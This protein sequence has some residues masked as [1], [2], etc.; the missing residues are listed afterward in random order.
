MRN[1][2][3]TLFILVSSCNPPPDEP[4]PPVCGNG[5]TEIG[6]ECDGTVPAVQTCRLH[7]FSGGTVT[8]CDYQC[9]IVTTGCNNGIDDTCFNGRIDTDEECDF[10]TVR[11]SDSYC[12]ENQ[13]CD[14]CL[15]ATYPQYP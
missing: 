2:L 5:F 13:Y 10:F 1:I 12:L 6:E 9:L 3:I 8:G 7:G 15:C 4:P 14:D 11:P